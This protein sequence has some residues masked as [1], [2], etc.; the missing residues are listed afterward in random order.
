MSKLISTSTFLQ[1]VFFLFFSAASA[2]DFVKDTAVK[3]ASFLAVNSYHQF[4]TPETGLYNGS[5][6]TYNTYYPLTINEGNP[7]FQSNKFDTGSVFYNN[8]LYENVPLLFDVIK[9]EVLTNDPSK[10][11][12]IRLNNERIS[13]FTIWK[14]TFVR[15]VTDSTSNPQVQ[16]G[17][18]DLLYQGKTSLYENVSKTIKEN[19]ASIQGINRY[20]VE[21]DE[22]FI[23]KDSRFYKVKNRKSLMGI[24][25]NKKKELTQFIKKNKLNVRKNTTYALAKIVAFY[26]EIN[27]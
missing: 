13:W 4:L 27:Q 9:V 22:Y 6:Y 10:V 8:V 23:K 15:I 2:Q 12:I 20:V 18:Y 17:F 24:L 3:T 21:S 11:Y 16:T 14:N 25:S 19:S 1:G 5:E 7:F 26:D